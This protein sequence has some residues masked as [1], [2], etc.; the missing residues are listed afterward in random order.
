MAFL[1]SQKDSGSVENVQFLPTGPYRASCARR[2]EVPLNKRAMAN[3]RICCVLCG[4]LRRVLAI[5]FIWNPLME[6]KISPK[7]AG[8]CA[9]TCVILDMVRVFN[10]SIAPVLLLFM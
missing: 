3:G 6:S 7:H 9:A 4:F 2:K 5:L 1:S 10:V 8:V